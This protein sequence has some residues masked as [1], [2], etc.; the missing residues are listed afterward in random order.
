MRAKAVALR[1]NRAFNAFLEGR[2]DED[3]ARLLHEAN[4]SVYQSRQ[5]N[6]NSSPR[7]EIN[8]EGDF[9]TEEQ[10]IDISV[11]CEL[12]HSLLTTDPPID[13]RIYSCTTG[14][15]YQ[16]IDD[17]IMFAPPLP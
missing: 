16:P 8:R 14:D 6:A 11:M 9:L 17:R 5:I 1:I 2:N 4:N 3:C 10:C 7:P 12:I 15:I 13:G